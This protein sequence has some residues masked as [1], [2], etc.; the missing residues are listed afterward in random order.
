MALSVHRVNYY[1]VSLPV[2]IVFQSEAV[3]S[4]NMLIPYMIAGKNPVIIFADYAL[5]PTPIVT[6]QMTD[7]V[8]ALIMH[9]IS[10]T[11]FTDVIETAINVS[12]IIRLKVHI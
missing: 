3:Y 4:V 7:H 6:Q 5:M 10:L 1:C 12:M 9:T 11:H 2:S 8:M